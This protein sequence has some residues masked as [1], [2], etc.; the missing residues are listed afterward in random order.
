MDTVCKFHQ[1]GH[2]K[3][4][5]K[6]KHQHNMHTCTKIN[7]DKTTCTARHPRP[8]LYYTRFGQCKF[9]TNFSYLHT[10]TNTESETEIEKLKKDLEHVLTLLN[11]KEKEMKDLE[12][13]VNMMQVQINKFPCDHCDSNETPATPATKHMKNTHQS[14]KEK[15]KHFRCN[16]GGCRYMARTKTIL[17]RHM[18]MKHKLDSNFVYPSSAEKVECDE[19][20]QEFFLDN[21]FAMHTYNEHQEGFD[22]GHCKKNLPGPDN[23]LEIHYNHCT[24]PCDGEPFCPCKI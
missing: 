8:C 21:T 17:K 22:C 6:C 23:M 24:F 4:G 18:T 16:F 13:K 9:G 14:E 5:S 2:C 10:N 20:D 12:E 15:E 7:C 3:F 1:S 11:V 19:C